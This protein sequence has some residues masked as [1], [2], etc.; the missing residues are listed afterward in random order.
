MTN[1][2][3]YEDGD[4]TQAVL[5]VPAGYD[6]PLKLTLPLMAAIG[7]GYTEFKYVGPMEK[8]DQIFPRSNRAW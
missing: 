2:H 7:R 5:E 8:P 3:V 4:G 6:P 1:R